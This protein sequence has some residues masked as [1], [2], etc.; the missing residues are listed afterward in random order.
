MW[1]LHDCKKFTSKKKITEVYEYIK[2][3]AIAYNVSYEDEITIDK[4]NILQASLLAMRRAIINLK[5]KPNLVLI[6]GNKLPKIKNYKLNFLQQ[7]WLMNINF[8]YLYL[9]IDNL[10]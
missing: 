3:N 7:S 1:L 8:Y 5:K 10:F 6:D 2:K 4:I 9:H